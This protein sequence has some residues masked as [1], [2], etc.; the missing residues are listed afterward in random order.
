MFGLDPLTSHGQSYFVVLFQQ[1]PVHLETCKDKKWKEN[2][3]PQTTRALQS[4]SIVI[5]SLETDGGL[6]QTSIFNE[7]KFRIMPLFGN[8]HVFAKLLLTASSNVLI[9]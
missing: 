4:D 6:Q 8:G 3:K 5:Q 2:K 7:S 1:L 9:C